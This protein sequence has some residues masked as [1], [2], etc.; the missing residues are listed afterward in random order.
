MQSWVHSEWNIYIIDA[1]AL[2]LSIINLCGIALTLKWL[3]HFFQNVISFYDAVHLI[4]NIFYMKLVWY[5]ECL[6]SIVDTD[7]RVL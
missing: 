7:G 4:C 6:V 2:A 3:G 1:D 5:N